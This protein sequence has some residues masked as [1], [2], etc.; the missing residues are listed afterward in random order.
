MISLSMNDGGAL[1][2]FSHW[3]WQDLGVVVRI[4]PGNRASNCVRRDSSVPG[5]SAFH[6]HGVAAAQWSRGLAKGIQRQC[7]ARL[8]VGQ[9]WRTDSGASAS[10]GRDADSERSHPVPEG[11]WQHCLTV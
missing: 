1:R 4:A 7:A 3:L 2:L 8:Q 11:V 9:L 10:A 6:A 5:H